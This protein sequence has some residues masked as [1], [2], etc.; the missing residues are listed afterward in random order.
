MR[1][2]LITATMILITGAIL[3][4]WFLDHKSLNST[5]MTLRVNCACEAVV[6][7]ENLHLYNV[8][9]RQFRTLTESLS[10]VRGELSTLRVANGSLKESIVE[11]DELIAKA[12]AYI[13]SKKGVVKSSRTPSTKFPYNIESVK[14][15]K[16][17]TG[18]KEK[19]SRVTHVKKDSDNGYRK[20][21]GKYYRVGK[22]PTYSYKVS[23]LYTNYRDSGNVLKVD[24]GGTS[25]TIKTVKDKPT[26]SYIIVTNMVNTITF[27]A[28][29]KSKTMGV[30]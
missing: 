9:H 26:A 1:N 3:F 14:G 5:I 25:K 23:F 12:K 21:D 2:S 17:V 24:C 8:S 28:Q 13:A 29:G 7:S 27:S 6:A 30:F 4:G 16:V 10:S 11:K 18:S 20:I 15:R 22:A 19:L